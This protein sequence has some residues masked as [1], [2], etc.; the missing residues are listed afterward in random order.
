[1]PV[2]SVTEVVRVFRRRRFEL[3]EGWRGRLIGAA[4][5]VPVLGGFL[6]L[7]FLFTVASSIG[8]AIERNQFLLLVGVVPAWVKSL[9]WGLVPFVA[10]M[11]MMTMAV[12]LLWR[13]RARSIAGRVYFTLL[14]LAGWSVCLALFDTGLIGL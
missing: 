4:P 5:W 2:Y 11:A 9:S 7:A 12:V 8:S 3:P 6:L 1:V 13:H 10:V 14:V